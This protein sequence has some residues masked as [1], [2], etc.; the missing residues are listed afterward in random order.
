MITDVRPDV[1]VHAGALSGPMLARNQPAAML[2]VNAGGTAAVLEG[3]SAAGARRL[4]H[5]SSIA[6]YRDRADRDPVVEDADVGSDDPY[7]AS[8]IAAEA[9]VKTVA[10]VRGIDAWIMR[11]SSIYGP[12]RRTPDL[13]GAL[14]AAGCQ[15][16]LVDV[17]D[18]R[19]GMRQ[20]VHVE[21]VAAALLAATECP[22][23][24]TVPVN[25]SGG[26]YRSE[27]EIGQLVATRLPG[28]KLHVVAETAEAWDGRI[29]PLDITRASRLLN[30]RPR[31]ALANGIAELIEG[32]P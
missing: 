28:L 8:K 9:I 13:I 15:G 22:A 32:S 2:D 19:G 30:Y 25:V 6:V 29:G 10:A 1:V 14:I 16:L 5:C 31:I 18:E 11:I 20:L 7:G 12:G 24:G 26:D 3:M 23:G 27:A 21:D 4:V 17:A